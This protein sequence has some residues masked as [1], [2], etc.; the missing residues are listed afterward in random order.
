MINRQWH[1]LTSDMHQ[2]HWWRVRQI[3]LVDCIST[4][5]AF[6]VRKAG[7]GNDRVWKGCEAGFPPFPHSLEIP[8]GFPTFPRPRPTAY[9]SFSAPVNS[10]HRHRKGLLTDVSGPQRNACP[11]TL[12]PLEAG[13]SP[14]A[15]RGLGS[16]LPVRNGGI[17]SLRNAIRRRT[18]FE[19]YLVGRRRVACHLYLRFDAKDSGSGWNRQRGHLVDFSRRF[20][21]EP[22][23]SKRNP[24]RG[25]VSQFIRC[26]APLSLH[27]GIA[28]R[29]RPGF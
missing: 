14:A 24:F 11:G 7:H 10:N 25:G 6:A 17:R 2:Q 5:P 21:M 4:H 20:R 15:F 19:L 22:K 13:A 18:A 23:V 26:E 8:S 16:A 12:T 9:I 29:I 3:A 1:S 28:C 27:P